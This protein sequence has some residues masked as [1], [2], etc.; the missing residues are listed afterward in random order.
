M[1]K[2]VD[3]IRLK[4]V[5]Y[6]NHFAGNDP[7]MA[8]RICAAAI[9]VAGVLVGFLLMAIATLPAILI[10]LFASGSVGYLARSFVSYRRRESARR[11]L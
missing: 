7:R 9:F 5:A 10:L 8:M 6:L 4:S 11:R 3:W 2:A 1:Q